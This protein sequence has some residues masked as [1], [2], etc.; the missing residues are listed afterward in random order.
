VT[1][2]DCF[3]ATPNQTVAPGQTVRLD[4]FAV[5]ANG[6][7]VAANFVWMTDAP[8]VV[9][10]SGRV[11]SAQAQQGTAKITAALDGGMPIMCSGEVELSNIGPPPPMGGLRVVVLD[12]ETGAPVPNA[13]VLIGQNT[14]GGTNSLGV[15]NFPVPNGEFS[16]SVFSDEHDFVTVH[17]V[18]ATDIRIPLNRQSGTGPVAGFKGQFDM[19]QVSTQGDFNLG[20]AG[21]SIPGGLVNF[22][23]STLLGDPFQTNF[24]IPGQG[25][26]DFPV[27]GGLVIYG[28]VFG[29]RL[30]IKRNYYVSSPGGARLGWGLAGKIPVTELISIFQGGGIDS[31][32]EALAVLLP[33]FNRFDHGVRPM[34]LTPRPRVTDVNDVDG[35]GN[36]MEQVPDY[37]NFPDETLRP[38]VRQQLITDIGVSNFPTLS[39]GPAEVAIIVGGTQL[40]STGFVPLGISATNDEDGDG[41]PDVR[42]LTMAPPYGSLVGG[43]F[44]LLSIAFR[45]DG[46]GGSNNGVEF[47]DEFSVALWNGQT[48]PTSI[49]LGTF[50]SSATVFED[51]MARS[52]TVDSP[53]GPLY[54]ARFVGT[55]RSWDVWAPGPAGVMGQFNHNFSVPTPP[56]GRSDIYVNSQKVLLDAIRTQVKIDDLLQPSGLPLYDAALVATGFARTRVR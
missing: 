55:D 25:A 47:P 29:L 13:D 48:L 36:T 43:R 34:Q 8:N 41:R 4:A 21:A 37:D 45:A 24:M 49:Q 31:V 42:R 39:D 17:G 44:A 26:I 22:D 56:M 7:G 51:P 2:Q 16:V 46:F 27:P 52:L 14:L 12:A 23:L 53:A 28:R 20:L 10:V 15:A 6:N 9:S 32:G 30:N 19:A 33:L 35:D 3:V 40:D 1:V 11:A 38:S 50:P 54:R 18:R 5:D